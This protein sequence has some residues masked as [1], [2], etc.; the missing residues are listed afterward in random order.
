LYN[1]A[2]YRN[3]VLDTKSPFDLIIPKDNLEAMTIIDAQ[4]EVKT[5]RTEIANANTIGNLIDKIGH[6]QKESI[7]FKSLKSLMAIPDDVDF[8]KEGFGK[9]I[10]AAFLNA[11]EDNSDFINRFLGINIL[12]F[13]N[14]YL[15]VSNQQKERIKYHT[16][17][18]SK[19][20]EYSNLILILSDSFQ[21]KKNYYSEYFS[22]M[23][24]FSDD[25]R[26]FLLYVGVTRAIN[27]LDVIFVSSNYPA[28]KKGF[29]EVFENVIDLDLVTTGNTKL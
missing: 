6:A 13:N 9:W 2:N 28:A 15:F 1:L 4:K 19:G 18:S 16:I 20:R 22:S 26:H 11:D 14:W 23:K 8:S 5:I 7:Y 25:Q 3:S 27:R 17:H 21:K 12:E 29:E 10:E 24:T